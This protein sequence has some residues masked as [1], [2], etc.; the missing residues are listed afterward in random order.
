VQHASDASLLA[1]SADF[2]WGG[3]PRAIRSRC[4][5][6]DKKSRKYQ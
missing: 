6:T 3:L 4:F 5:Q 1:L 2:A